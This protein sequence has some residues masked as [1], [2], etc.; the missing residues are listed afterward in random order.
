MSAARALRIW[1][2]STASLFARLVLLCLRLRC[3]HLG[4]ALAMTMIGEAPMPPFDLPVLSVRY[5]RPRIMKRGSN[6][7]WSRSFS[8]SSRRPTGDAPSPSQDSPPPLADRCVQ[9]SRN[10]R[11][12]TRT[13]TS[14]ATFPGTTLMAHLDRSAACR[15]RVWAA[16]VGT[17]TA[18]PSHLRTFRRIVNLIDRSPPRRAPG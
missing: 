17:S 1:C 9:G 8:H 5:I 16:A 6:S 7:E 4:Q 14:L 10:A 13:P 15:W 18:G 12:I 11:W 3:L 2:K